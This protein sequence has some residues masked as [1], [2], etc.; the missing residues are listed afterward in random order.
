MQL[1]DTP[2]VVSIEQG[3]DDPKVHASRLQDAYYNAYRAAE[4]VDHDAGLNVSCES[5]LSQ[6]LS[7]GF[8]LADFWA[9]RAYRLDRAL[10]L[11]MESDALSAEQR[12]EIVAVLVG[13]KNLGRDKKLLSDAEWQIVVEYRRTDVPGKQMLRTLVKRIAN[14]PANDEGGA[15]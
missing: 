10:R 3:S 7:A 13:K 14:S 9:R 4:A 15:R 1:L 6:M 12:A 8:R 2:R 5:P 11:V